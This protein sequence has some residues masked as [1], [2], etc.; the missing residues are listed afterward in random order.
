MSGS[1]ASGA[2]TPCEVPCCTTEGAGAAVPEV[3]DAAGADDVAD[4][5][6]LTTSASAARVLEEK[7]EAVTGAV[8]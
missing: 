6:Q 8:G 5:A 3:E 4:F 2:S 1:D 7:C